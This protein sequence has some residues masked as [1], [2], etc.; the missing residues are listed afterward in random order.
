MGVLKAWV[1]KTFQNPKGNSSGFLFV[2]LWVVSSFVICNSEGKLL[3]SSFLLIQ[4]N[5]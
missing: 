3:E 5:R 1:W 2:C 4:Q